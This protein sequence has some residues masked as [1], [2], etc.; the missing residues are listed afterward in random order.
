MTFFCGICTPGRAAGMRP[1]PTW[2]STAAAPTPTSGGPYC[3]PRLVTMPSPFWP[4]QDEQPTRKSLRPSAT[5]DW[6]DW[7]VSALAGESTAYAPPVTSR[8]SSRTTSPASGL[9]RLAESRALRNRIDVL[10]S[11]VPGLAGGDVFGLLQQVDR[12]EQTDPHDVDEM[13]VV[14]HDDRADGLFMSE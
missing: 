1:V 13:P 4:W 6:S 10:R 11:V 8:P 12:G 2:K 9:R 3:V 7:F 5:V 14:R